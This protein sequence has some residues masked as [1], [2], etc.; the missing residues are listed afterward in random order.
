MHTETKALLQKTGEKTRG[1]KP[2]ARIVLR[3][4]FID[5]PVSEPHP[6]TS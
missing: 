5:N 3:C 2:G 1:H 6:V 4:K